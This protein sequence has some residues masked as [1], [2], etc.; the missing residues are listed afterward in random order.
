MTAFRLTLCGIVFL[1][2]LLNTQAGGLEQEASNT[3]VR[4][5][6]YDSRAIAVAAVGSAYY[7][8]HIKPLE[9]AFRKAKA[10]GNEELIQELEPE[11]WARRKQ[12]HR[13]GFSTAPVDEILEYI[14]DDLPKIA[15][16][17]GVGPII[18]K[19]D[20]EALAKYTSEE[21]VDVTM[22]LVEAFKPKEKSLQSAIEVQKHPPVPMKALEEHM[23]GEGH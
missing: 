5:G 12:T 16:K 6:V 11:V 18:S 9:D 2:A 13:Q 20:G 15:A 3:P 14:Q 1:A 21:Q 19:W 22:L 8:D 7:T 4:I 23:A 10:E 17:A